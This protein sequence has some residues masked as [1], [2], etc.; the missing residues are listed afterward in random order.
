MEKDKNKTS[1]FCSEEEVPYFRIHHNLLP[2]P[3]HYSDAQRQYLAYRSTLL[4]AALHNEIASANSA[5]T[6]P[7]G[8]HHGDSNHFTLAQQIYANDMDTKTILRRQLM[9]RKMTSSDLSL[10]ANPASYIP[11]IYGMPPNKMLI[12]SASELPYPTI[13]AYHVPLQ[14][15]S[16]FP[17]GSINPHMLYRGLSTE[18]TYLSQL[19]NP[20]TP[21]GYFFDGGYTPLASTRKSSFTFHPSQRSPVQNS[22]PVSPVSVHNVQHNQNNNAQTGHH[23]EQYF[24]SNYPSP[25]ANKSPYHD[26]N[27][28]HSA[29]SP[30][31]QASSPGSPNQQ[32][33]SLQFQSS[34][35]HSLNGSAEG[36]YSDVDIVSEENFRKNSVSS[37]CS[38]ITVSSPHAMMPRQ[39]C[40]SSSYA[41][42]L[43]TTSYPQS[44]KV[45]STQS[46][47]SLGSCNVVSNDCNWNQASYS[48]ASIHPNN[49][50]SHH[51]KEEIIDSPPQCSVMNTHCA[52]PPSMIGSPYNQ[53]SVSPVRNSP[54]A[55]PASSCSQMIL[56]GYDVSVVEKPYHVQYSISSASTPSM[57]RYPAMNPVGNS[58]ADGRFE[59]MKKCRNVSNMVSFHN[60][61]FKFFKDLKKVYF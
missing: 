57:Q 47:I 50:P 35:R 42:T 20:N 48:N 56:D 59:W 43:N 2:F 30:N 24:P 25:C 8:I 40:S 32:A 13:G 9:K 61:F 14:H 5:M 46:Q 6:S 52:S 27:Y 41:S 4:S 58:A 38:G 39:H 22:E 21:H 17:E 34:L 28:S 60:H 19:H 36:L 23:D 31:S 12:R 15:S 16:S 18:E 53:G 10:Y 51:L 11:E 49:M 3:E 26:T 37:M 7:T 55:Y 33:S 54:E 44:N 1:F 45:Q 29:G